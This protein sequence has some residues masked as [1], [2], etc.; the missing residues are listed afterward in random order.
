MQ[1]HAL[2]VLLLLPHP[3][4]LLTPLLPLLLLLPLLPC[5][6]AAVLCRVGLTSTRCVMGFLNHVTG[7]WLYC[8]RC[9][10]RLSVDSTNLEGGGD[11][12]EIGGGELGVVRYTTT[13]QHEWQGS[14]H[15][16]VLCGRKHDI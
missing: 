8:L 6:A 11:G 1:R 5:R 7:L 3:P 9:R 4:R 15:G 10:R 14:T 2:L 12:G 16:E 13:A